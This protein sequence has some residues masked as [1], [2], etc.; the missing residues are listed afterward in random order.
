[1]KLGGKVKC[2]YTENFLMI[3]AHSACVFS[4]TPL[5]RTKLAL[6]MHVIS[7]WNHD[8]PRRGNLPFSFVPEDYLALCRKAIQ[9]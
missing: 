5:T 8:D 7:F 6:H 1:M 2:S 4:E 9:L 3:K